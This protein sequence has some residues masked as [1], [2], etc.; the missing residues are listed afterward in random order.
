MIEEGALKVRLNSHFL[1]LKAYLVLPFTL[2]VLTKYS[3]P[4]ER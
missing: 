2:V 3:F 4:E 1:H